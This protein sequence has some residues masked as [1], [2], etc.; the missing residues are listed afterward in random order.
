MFA[1]CGY[2][3]FRNDFCCG[4]ASYLYCYDGIHNTN[5]NNSAPLKKVDRN[6]IGILSTKCEKPNKEAGKVKAVQESK[7][8]F[9]V[10]PIKIIFLLSGYPWHCCYLFSLQ[11][12]PCYLF[13][14]CFNCSVLI[15][16]GR[17]VPE[18]SSGCV[19]RSLRSKKISK[20]SLSGRC[21]HSLS[22]QCHLYQYLVLRW[23]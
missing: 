13:L 23:L 7:L 16:C 6:D 17:L 5:R 14:D 11:L 9:F 22:I 4:Y 12:T 18:H 2:M 8:Y 15:T 20:Q 3:P 19:D 10:F 21:E 1:L